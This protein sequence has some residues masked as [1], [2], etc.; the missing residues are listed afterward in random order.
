MRKKNQDKVQIHKSDVKMMNFK[1]SNSYLI[2]CLEINQLSHY[3]E[4]TLVD[5]LLMS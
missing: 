4:G 1:Q 2:S 5:Q 3:Q